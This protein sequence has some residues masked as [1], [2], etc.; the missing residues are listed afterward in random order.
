[1]Q[2]LFFIGMKCIYD[3]DTLATPLLWLYKQLLGLLSK[4]L[5]RRIPVLPS[6]V[7]ALGPIKGLVLPIF[8]FIISRVS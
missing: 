7:E 4:L 5:G 2:I 3:A 1:M 8:F 6:D